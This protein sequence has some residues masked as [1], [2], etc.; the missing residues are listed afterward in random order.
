MAT[1]P[2]GQPIPNL[3]TYVWVIIDGS[4]E[5]PPYKVITDKKGCADC[6][7]RGTKVMPAFWNDDKL[8]K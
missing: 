2:G 4:M 5:M 7:V 3:G 8:L 1:I 6:T